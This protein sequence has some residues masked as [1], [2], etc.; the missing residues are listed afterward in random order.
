MRTGSATLRWRFLHR[1]PQDRA[2]GLFAVE[3]RPRELLLKDLKHDGL[4][5]CHAQCGLLARGRKLGSHT[6]RASLVGAFGLVE[7]L[8]LI[9]AMPQKTLCDP[10]CEADLR[11]I[12]FDP[13]RRRVIR[14]NESLINTSL[15]PTSESTFRLVIDCVDST[16]ELFEL[17]KNRYQRQ[18]CCFEIEISLISIE[19]GARSLLGV[20]LCHPI[21]IANIVV[22]HSA[23]QGN[24]IPEEWARIE[25]ID[26]SAKLRSVLALDGYFVVID[27]GHG[28]YLGSLRGAVPTGCARRPLSRRRRPPGETRLTNV[29]AA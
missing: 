6:V 2:T 5:L 12:L 24:E 4:N 11:V 9:Q 1:G 26:Q 28:C 3:L 21:L 8:F 23:R 29:E 7:R 25:G 19:L 14:G 15:I 18:P 10:E 22:P 16:A 13:F 27:V 17:L 20:P